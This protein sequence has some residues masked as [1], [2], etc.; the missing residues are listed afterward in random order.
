MV[1]GLLGLLGTLGTLEP[2]GPL[3]PLRNFVI[4]VL[5]A[6]QSPQ[7]FSGEASL[8]GLL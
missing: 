5:Q 4:H 7:V 2:L 6:G 8:E 3:G 1:L